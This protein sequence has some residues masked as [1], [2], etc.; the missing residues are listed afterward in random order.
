MLDAASGCRVHQSGEGPGQRLGPGEVAGGRAPRETEGHVAGVRQARVE[1]VPVKREDVDA[2]A[3][4]PE[5]DDD[6]QDLTAV[7]GLEGV[8][9]APEPVGHALA[10]PRFD[11]DVDEQV[12]PLS[13][14]GDLDEEVH[15][16][17][18]ASGDIRKELLIKET[19]P[20]H[21]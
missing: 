13:Q 2:G 15:L 3:T 20:G 21:V 14:E 17:T 7:P 1:R 16:P 9:V 11:L 10:C 8:A 6:G 18:L 12:L 5:I 19:R 4:P